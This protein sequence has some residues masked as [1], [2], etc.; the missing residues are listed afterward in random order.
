MSLL[1]A[2]LLASAPATRAEAADATSV[3][4][5][6]DA[7]WIVQNIAQPV[8]TG[9]PF[10]EVR[11]SPLLKSPLR[12]SGEYRRPDAD[13]LVREVRSPYAETTTLAQG[14]VSIARE[15]RR[16]RTFSLS[17]A[18]ELASLQQVFGSLLAG[19]AATVE[20]H[21]RLEPSGTRDGWSL[22]MTPKEPALA[23]RL[24]S[25]TLH[26]QGAELRCIETESANGKEL[27]RT[28]LAGAAVDATGEQTEQAL[29][30]MCSGAAY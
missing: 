6:I 17:R 10:V 18:P 21:Y 3:A 19:D 13:T 29:V 5:Q 15:G 25:I 1:A 27:Q 16:A 2:T 26:G 7:N 12:I 28:L 11:S 30:A 23:K 4:D 20:Q 14:K 24:R 9:T 22:L 8:Q